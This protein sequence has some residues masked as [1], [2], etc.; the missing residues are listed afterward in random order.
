[1]LWEIT[2]KY[3]IRHHDE[4]YREKNT[5]LILLITVILYL[6]SQLISNSDSVRYYIILD[7]FG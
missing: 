4:K 7:A 3:Q 1:M 2:G 5:L 6:I